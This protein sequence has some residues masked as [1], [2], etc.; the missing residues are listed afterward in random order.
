MKTAI[1]STIFLAVGLFH[2][3]AAAPVACEFIDLY[4]WHRRLTLAL[5]SLRGTNLHWSLRPAARR[6][7]E[8]SLNDIMRLASFVS[9]C[10]GDV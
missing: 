9:I 10:N 8:D 3:V 6:S 7:D 1:I 4:V 5:N 2:Y